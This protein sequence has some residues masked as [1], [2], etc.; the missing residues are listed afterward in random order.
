VSWWHRHQG[1]I[2]GLLLAAVVALVV[3]CALLVGWQRD[4]A[5]DLRSSVEG[6]CDVLGVLLENRADRDQTAK[7]FA[8]I[9][10][11]NPEQFDKLIERAEKG[12]ERL[13]AAA[14]KLSC[15][16]PKHTLDGLRD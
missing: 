8:P 9:R 14:P 16:L 3:L 4:Q 15:K 7:L 6:N 13:V 1:A 5:S 12:D 10:E 2:V 11:Q